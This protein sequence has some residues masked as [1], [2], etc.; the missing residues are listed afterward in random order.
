MLIATS[1]QQY[2]GAYTWNDTHKRKYYASQ[3]IKHKI[4]HYKRHKPCKT[5]EKFC[6]SVW[7]MKICK[8]QRL[9]GYLNDP[10]VLSLICWFSAKIPLILCN[11][12]IRDCVYFQLWKFLYI[13]DVIFCCRPT[14]RK[15]KRL[16]I[17][18]DN[19]S[20]LRWL[21]KSMPMNIHWV[22]QCMSSGK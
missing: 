22:I 11:E 9:I 17:L 19:S 4:K 18:T 15:V 5:T 10:S 13:I 6:I 20:N 21:K 1:W 12:N 16:D 14:G 7:S 2:C 8:L 3:L